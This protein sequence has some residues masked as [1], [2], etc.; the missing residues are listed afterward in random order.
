MIKKTY[1]L[2]EL[3][4]NKHN[5]NGYRVRQYVNDDDIV[6]LKP[7]FSLFS[8]PRKFKHVDIN[9]CMKCFCEVKK[10]RKLTNVYVL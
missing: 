7:E 2:C 4:G 5:G 6:P 3:C 1:K 8:P 10:T 9:L